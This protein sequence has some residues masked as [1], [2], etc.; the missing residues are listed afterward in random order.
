MTMEK[1]YATRIKLLKIWEI[2]THYSSE[3]KP[4][5]STDI[6]L[7]LE[8]TGIS[9]DRR[10]LYGDIEL[11]SSCGYPVKT[12]RSK[13]NL[14]YT[15]SAKFS[16]TELKA[17]V[18]AVEADKNIPLSQTKKL[19]KKLCLNAETEYETI[20]NG[21][22]KPM[23]CQ[24][25]IDTS[26]FEN[27]AVIDEAIGKNK[28]ITF[29]TFSYNLKKQKVADKTTLTLS[30]RL[31]LLHEGYYYL[32]CSENLN[33]IK[34]FRVDSIYSI[35]ITNRK[36]GAFVFLDKLRK[37]AATMIAGKVQPITFICENQAIAAVMDKFGVLVNLSKQGENHFSFTVDTSADE[38]LFLWVL[39]SKGKIK[40]NAPLSLRNEFASFVKSLTEKYI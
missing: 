15:D 25:A 24:K 16:V 31:V 22:H 20:E 35:A 10:T 11:L 17:L 18:D 8:E 27:L 32:V 38:S 3:D 21:K 34:I 40:I 6:L 29:N 37:T 23:F 12:V 1:E 26:L 2:L 30:P 36:Q 4:I 19:I 39:S 33:N 13:T 14:Y 7:K 9:C 28:K 5:S